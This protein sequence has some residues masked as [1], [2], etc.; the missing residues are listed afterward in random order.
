MN[1]CRALGLWNRNRRT[2][3][4]NLIP[5]LLFLLP[6]GAQT[7]PLPERPAHAPTGT[8]FAEQIAPL[9]LE[10][11][12]TEILSQITSGNIP[13]FLRHLCPVQVIN[14]FAGCTNTATFFVTPDYLAI[15]SDADYLLTPISPNTTQR[16]ADALNCSLP[17]RKM[18]DDIYAAAPV[19]LSPLPIPP[20]PAMTTSEIFRQH[21][22]SV[23]TQRTEQ[24]AAHPLGA[25]VAGHKKDVVLSAKLAT[26][27]GKVAIYGWHKTNGLP[28]QPLYLGHTAAWV[29]YSQCSRLVQQQMLV[30]GRTTSVASVLADPSLA[31]LLSDE[32]PLANPRYPTNALPP[33]KAGQGPHPP[34]TALLFQTN[35]LFN[36]RT[37]SFSFAPEVRIQVNEPAEQPLKP[38]K[39]LLL[40]FYALPNGNTTG[41]TIGKQLKPGEDWHYDI[42]HI[43]A[44]T[45]FLR[46]LVPDRLIVVACL[47]NT[48]KSWPAWRKKYGDKPIPEIIEKVKNSF[49]G[50][51]LEIAL[52]GHSGGGSLLFGYLNALETIPDDV[53][54]LAFLDS[55]YA[56]D[57]KLGHKDK[58]AAWLKASARHFLCV[59]A[60][61]DAVAL[62]DGKPFVSAAG[63]TWGKSHEMQR[64]LAD[65]FTF[66]SRADAGFQRFSALDGRIQFLLKEN[67]EKK[68]FHT[69]QVERN[70]FIHC[71]V[72]GTTNE[73]RR[74]KYFGPRAYSKWIQPE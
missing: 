28:I 3:I 49:A 66:A 68:I 67:P 30:N 72:S 74:Y 56:Y 14:V 48:L 7:L 11:R 63:G 33:L 69:V 50:R 10:T 71:L 46:E 60:Y 21:N 1:G 22:A 41:Q 5:L 73:S 44:Q 35:R 26:A 34:T 32:G 23:R 37:A 53:V 27:P 61:N 12:E 17:T 6:A 25:L 9:D 65:V 59:L 38:Q 42:Q 57:S 64:D 47:E 19:K 40:I 62:L 55:N 45:R 70:G 51:E 52:S 4:L 58:L 31:G 8:E 36:E 16:I 29:D 18:V 54:R 24:L 13:P 2:A 15:G 20:S 43:G 39:K